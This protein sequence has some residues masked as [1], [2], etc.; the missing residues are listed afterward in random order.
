MKLVKFL[1]SVIVI[2][3][4]NSC[5]QQSVDIQNNIEEK[6][7]ENID[8]LPS[9]NEGTTKQSIVDFVTQVTAKENSNYVEREDRIATF[10]NDGNLWVEQPAYF[11]LFFAQSGRWRS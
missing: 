7:S 1:I 3:L 2:T 4:I 5:N 9:W 6:S 8:P 11:Q 10:D